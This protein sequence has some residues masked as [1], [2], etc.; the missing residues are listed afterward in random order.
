YPGSENWRRNNYG[1]GWRL[2]KQ[3]EGYLSYH[4]GWWRGFR[5]C[6]IRDVEKERTLII[7]SNTD[8]PGRNLKFW[9]VYAYLSDQ[10][11]W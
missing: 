8:I 1:L 9:D 5:T 4:F 2:K 11:R 7:L 6:F 10:E 3:N